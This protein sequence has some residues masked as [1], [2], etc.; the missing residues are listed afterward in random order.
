V[1]LKDLLVYVDQT[2]G[3]HA[4][5]ELGVDLAGRHGSRLT[6]LFV[7]EISSPQQE[8]LRAAELGL[9]SA[10]GLD[11]LNATILASIDE[12]ARRL[13]SSFETLARKH[14]V[15]FE[16]RTADGTSSVVVPQQ[17]R[18]ADLCIVGQS[19]REKGAAVGYSFSEQ[20]LFVTG[21]PVVFVPS[22][23][24]F[25][26]LGRHVLVAW[27][28]SRA[29]ARAVNDALPLIER[30]DRTTVLTVNSADY[31]ESHGAPP[32]T[33]LIEHLKRH[34][35]SVDAVQLEKVPTGSIAE[36]LQTQARN[37]GA[38]IMVAG[39]FGHPKLWEKLLGGVTHDL[40][41]HMR[42]PILMSH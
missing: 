40:L 2:E 39:A 33:L 38:D 30:A 16:W 4:R 6:A 18:Y 13:R 15:R 5:M 42:L 36:A 10:E 31:I 24:R 3:A 8:L 25:A 12:A 20:L 21:R 17:A 32:A 19:E 7:R 34:S 9:V 28:S 14:E 11:Q 27:N 37:L 1:A 22:D 26:T 41:H 29:A 23:G 35:P